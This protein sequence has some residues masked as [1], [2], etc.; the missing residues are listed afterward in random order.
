MAIIDRPPNP[1]RPV[2]VTI[3]AQRRASFADGEADAQ[4]HLIDFWSLWSVLG[5]VLVA[6]L[7]FALSQPFSG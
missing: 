7:L 3:P 2:R 4:S 5:V 1:S 6:L